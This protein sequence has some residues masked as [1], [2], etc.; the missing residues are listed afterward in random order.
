MK[1]DVPVSL[2]IEEGQSEEFGIEELC[3]H[4]KRVLWLSVR[5]GRRVVYKGLTEVLRHHPEEIASLRKEYS[6]GLRI[7]C[8]GVVRFYS[9]ELHPQLGPII[10]MEY[11]DG[12]TLH[13]YLMER[14]PSLD[15]RLKISMDIAESV[16]TMHGAGILHRDLKPDNILIRKRDLRP[17]IIDFGHADAED[18]MIYKNAVGT[19]QYGSPEQQVLSGGSMA[20]DIYSLGKNLEKLLPERRYKAIIDACISADESERPDIKW[21]IEHLSNSGR[22]SSLWKWI[23][24]IMPVLLL[25]A[26]LLLY[27]SS[28]KR[29]VATDTA[30]GVDA[31]ADSVIEVR[32][33]ES[34]PVEADT[35]EA[36]PKPESPSAAKE[37]DMAE[38]PS[39]EKSEIVETTA[40]MK[41]P[42]N[43][44]AIVDKYAREAD[45]INKRYGKLS[46]IENIE[47]NQSLRLKRGKEHDALSDSMMNELTDLGADESTRTKAYWDL[48]N[49]IVMETNRIDG[50]DEAREKFMQNY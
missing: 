9:F 15:Q 2:I 48:W 44:S 18:F 36:S 6:I 10:V 7:D 39:S 34:I 38:P 26:A 37:R 43:I 35:D 11:V 19:P 33:I 47:E 3:R 27:F 12:F 14:T 41:I 49:Y 45:N 25:V 46:Y 22:G 30:T 50:V 1:D 24:G 21:V 8:E 32:T 17:K 23:T 16:A 5:D 13:E 28:G 42:D 29:D 4:P 31:A 40:N 20:G